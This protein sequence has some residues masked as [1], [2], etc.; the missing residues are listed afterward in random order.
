[1]PTA[2][3]QAPAREAATSV[4]ATLLSTPA[5]NAVGSGG[6][7]SNLQSGDATDPP[8]ASSSKRLKL[9]SLASLFLIELWAGVTSLSSAMAESG[10]PLGAFC[11]SNPQTP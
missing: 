9:V 10:A 1:M 5:T 7:G 11:E 2:P 3:D 6:Q 4:L 8:V